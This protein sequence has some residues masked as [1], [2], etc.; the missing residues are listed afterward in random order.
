MEVRKLIIILV[1]LGFGYWVYDRYGYLI[2]SAQN[3][4]KSTSV[5]VDPTALPKV[6]TKDVTLSHLRLQ[7]G[8]TISYFARD[9]PGARSM[10]LGSGGVVYVGTRAQGVVYAIEDGDKDGVADT[11][12]VVASGLN[13]PNG[14]V[15][16]DGELYVAEINRVIKFKDIDKN[17]K[18]KPT[19]E[20][21]YDKLPSDTHHG[22][23]YMALGPDNKLYLGIGAPC[24][25]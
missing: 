13:N 21:I 18:N 15:Y 14:V 24:N 25:V 16:H 3:F 8:Y 20:V 2:K 12:Y 5:S 17:Y 4:P 6:E 23:R 22:W 10:A 9:V 19:S 7:D 11:R 1:I